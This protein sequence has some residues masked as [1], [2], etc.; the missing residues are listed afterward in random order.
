MTLI[1]KDN[2][3]S[4]FLV[5]LDENTCVETTYV[6]YKNKH[7]VCFSSMA[8]CPIGCTFCVSGR[9]KTHRLLTTGE[10]LLQ[11]E[12]ALKGRDLKGKPI[13]FS[14]MGEG[15]PMLNYD[16]V[17]RAL[18]ELGTRYPNSKLAMSTSG[19]KPYLIKALAREEFPVPFKLQISI[20]STYQHIRDRLM[21]NA[22]LLAEIVKFV[23]RYLESPHDIE[24]NYVLLD[25]V[26]DGT[27]DAHRL[28]AL[29]NGIMIK[30][31]KLNPIPESLF[32]YTNQ[33]DEFCEVLTQRGA[34]YEFYA[35]DGTD[36]DAACGQLS[37]KE[38][39]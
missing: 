39:L 22:G 19:A 10:M 4:K 20:H 13:L 29:A 17:V 1:S 28:A 24:F 23:P 35:T 14:C 37:Y 8:G 16:N 33:Y 27:N 6:N 9:N 32:Q 26:N 34:D 36:I 38:T 5:Q 21:P 30:L 11:C 12:Q 15:E 31:N 3:T 25:G 18:K 2:K 7:I